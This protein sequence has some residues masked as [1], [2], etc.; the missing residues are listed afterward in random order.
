MGKDQLQQQ[1][2]IK[3]E[4]QQDVDFFLCN[5]DKPKNKKNKKRSSST[6]Y[7]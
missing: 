5:E 3:K 6:A 4:S 7:Y 1:V 2:K